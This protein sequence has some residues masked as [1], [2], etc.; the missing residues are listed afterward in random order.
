MKILLF[1]SLMSSVFTLNAQIAHDLEIFSENG[2]KFTLIL[3]GRKMNE[4]PVSNIQ[5]VDTDKDYFNAV[6]EF[7]DA[8]IPSIEK[9][10]LQ[11]AE[12]NSDV[13]KYP[14]SCVYK[15]INKKGKYSLRFASRSRK[16]IQETIIIYNNPEPVNGKIIISW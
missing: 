16:K 10:F 4:T 5:I 6:I 2:E 11:I 13:D 14:V 8:S 12:P 3:N 15:I 9:K 7:E 1:L